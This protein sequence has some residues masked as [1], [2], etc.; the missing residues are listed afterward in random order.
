MKKPFLDGFVNHAR[1][2]VLRPAAHISSMLKVSLLSRSRIGGQME[3]KH[4]LGIEHRG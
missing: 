1:L 4:M 2:L 3:A